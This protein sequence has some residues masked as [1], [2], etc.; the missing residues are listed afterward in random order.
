MIHELVS[1]SVPHLCNDLIVQS[2]F[3]W[4]RLKY[5]AV[6]KSDPA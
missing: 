6:T 3:I 1:D 4:D 2:D 5:V